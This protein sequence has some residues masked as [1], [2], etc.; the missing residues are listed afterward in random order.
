[1]A[2]THRIFYSVLFCPILFY[3]V[4]FLFHLFNIFLKFELQ[5]TTFEDSG[6]DSQQKQ[7]ILSPLYPDRPWD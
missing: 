7:A 3:S 6:L 2:R 5:Y 1:M 4:P